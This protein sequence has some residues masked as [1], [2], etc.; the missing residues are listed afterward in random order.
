MSET[1]AVKKYRGNCHCGAFVFEV[2]LPEIKTVS[3]CNCSI[4][5]KKGYLW[6][7]P[8]QPP[9]IVKDEGRL[10]RYAFASKGIHHHFCGYCGSP[11]WGT[12]A[13]YPED[14]T[15]SINARVLQDLDIW[16]LDV[17]QLDGARLDPQYVTT[18]YSGPE[19]SPAGFENGK[20]Y[21]GSCHCGAV[22]AAVKLNAALEDG[23]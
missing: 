19:P 22:T 7:S 21:H 18:P 3:E 23:S 10:V 5:R 14:Q 6:V 4:C 2:E 1:E 12:A 11:V 8:K 15:M 16:S 20:V 13:S 17:K 9:T